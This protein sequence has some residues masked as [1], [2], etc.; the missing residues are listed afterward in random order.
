MVLAPGREGR[1]LATNK[2]AGTFMA[3][4]AAAA[5]AF[6]IRSK[7]DLYRIDSNSR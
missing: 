4:P 3:T 6:F 2:L 1:I 7:T 5:H